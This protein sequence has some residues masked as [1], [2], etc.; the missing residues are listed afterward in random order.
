GFEDVTKEAGLDK[1][2]STMGSN[3][4]DFD[5]DG[6]LDFYLGTGEPDLAMLV[7]NR[8]F[9]NVAGK[10]FADITA[11]SRTGNL[12]KGHGVACGDWRNCGSID[13]F[14]QTGGIANGDKYHNCLYVNPGQGNNWLTVKLVGKK[15]NR[16][17]I[18][19]RIKAVVGSS[20]PR[21]IHRQVSSGS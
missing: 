20:T 18:G 1:V 10:R 17:A 8:M 4:A 9:K 3:F 5:N 14:A 21:E 15:T 19:A 11:S 7:P 2:Y 12:Q 16:P 6:Y 13:I